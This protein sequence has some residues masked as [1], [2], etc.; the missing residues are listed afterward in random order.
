MQLYY[1]VRGVM[2]LELTTNGPLRPLHSAIT[3]TGRR[4][5]W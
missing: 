2:G 3:A 1:G 5:R 4:I